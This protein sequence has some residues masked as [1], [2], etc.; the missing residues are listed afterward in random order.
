MVRSSARLRFSFLFLIWGCSLPPVETGKG[1]DSFP[2][3]YQQLW[4]S[5]W[6]GDFPVVTS[7]ADFSM[8]WVAHQRL[9]QNWLLEQGKRG[10]VFLEATQLRLDW[11]QEPAAHYLHARILQDPL[12][13]RDTFLKLTE[14]F[15]QHPWISMGCSA[16]HFHLGELAQAKKYFHKVRLTHQHRRC[17][18]LRAFYAGLQL[19]LWPHP[20]L[21]QKTFK[22]ACESGNPELFGALAQP[23]IF[24]EHPE[25]KKNLEYQILFRR[26][27]SGNIQEKVLALLTKEAHWVRTHPRLPYPELMRRLSAGFGALDLPGEWQKWP[28]SGLAGFAFVL[29]PTDTESVVGQVIHQTN[30]R[31]ILGQTPSRGLVLHLLTGVRQVELAWNG[32]PIQLL[33]AEEQISSIDN[34]PSGG[35]VFTGFYVVRESVLRGAKKL[36]NQ[37]RTLPSIPSEAPLSRPLKQFSNRYLPEDF[38]LSRRLRSSVKSLEEAESKEWRSLTIHEAGHLADT[39]PLF[40]KSFPP[41]EMFLASLLSFWRWGSVELFLEYRAQL[42][43]IAVGQETAWI[44]A[45]TLDAARNPGHP[46]FLPYRFLVLKLLAQAKSAGFPS[47][48]QWGSAEIAKLSEEAHRLLEVQGL[49]PIAVKD[50]KDLLTK[51]T[52]NVF[53]Q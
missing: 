6:E 8:S 37:S 12:E 3:V 2:S 41:G 29:N 27:F 21:W 49:Q 11:P 14:R 1:M 9:R 44:W 23:E 43:A 31:V 46:Y 17:E 36:F 48:Y 33:L 19:G 26:S 13:Q 10:Q 35:A 38:G 32:R 20:E 42:R 28:L 51:A 53:V 40:E 39:L 25:W 34:P 16:S 45:A 7:A 30:L 18:P 5:N 50:M 47:L 22:Q 4:L 52:I 24:A 15:P